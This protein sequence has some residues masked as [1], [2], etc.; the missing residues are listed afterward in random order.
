ME[1]VP[2][3]TKRFCHPSSEQYT[4]GSLLRDAR[5][6]F[7]IQSLPNPLVLRNRHAWLWGPGVK[8]AEG[9]GSTCFLPPFGPCRNFQRECAHTVSASGLH[10]SLGSHHN[11]A[12]VQCTRLRQNRTACWPGILAVLDSK[13]ALPVC[14]CFP[15]TS[16]R[17]ETLGLGVSNTSTRT[18][19]RARHTSKLY[20]L[21]SSLGGI[22]YLSK[23]T[24]RIPTLFGASFGIGPSG[25]E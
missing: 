12:I 8:G 25:T 21:L 10:G 18:S 6:W 16:C 2:F 20:L 13:E 7:I 17:L 11:H 19:L 15:L 5:V 23:P 3:N 22:P 4:F 14:A 1:R 9:D 24:L